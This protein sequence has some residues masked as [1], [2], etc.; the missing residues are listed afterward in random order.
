[1][2]NNLSLRALAKQS[3]FWIA[4]S[5]FALLAMTVMSALAQDEEA[6]TKK[7]QPAEEPQG[8][9]YS[10]DFCE[11]SVT[12]PS[13][14]YAARRCEDEGK[15]R[16][17]DLVSYTQVYEMSS[18]INFRIICNPIDSAV[19][20]EYSAEV[21]QATLRAMTRKTVVEE[22]NSGFREGDGYKQAGL[23]GA[24]KVGRTPMIYIAQLW[25]GKQSAFSVE[26]ELI[27]EA[28][29]TADQAFSDI[30]KTVRYSGVKDVEPP[31]KTKAPE[32]D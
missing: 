32:R 16:C 18:T 22:Y 19:Y 26:A 8:H 17:Y 30:L 7:E 6:Q 25:I 20:D 4:A 23:A 31:V 28:H 15:D 2:I 29:E 1:M 13:A 3:R 12:F 5:A 14:P 10:P 9:T 11:F 21:M 27:G 24:G